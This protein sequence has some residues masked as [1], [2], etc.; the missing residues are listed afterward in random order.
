MDHPLTPEVQLRTGGG[1]DSNSLHLPHFLH[2]YTHVIKELLLQF[3]TPS[4]QGVLDCLLILLYNSPIL[5]FHPRHGTFIIILNR[6]LMECTHCLLFLLNHLHSLSDCVPLP[7]TL[8]LRSHSAAPPS[9]AVVASAGRC[10]S[11]A[12]QC[13]FPRHRSTWPKNSR[14]ASAAN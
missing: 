5:F 4:A 13:R 8:P 2:T 3:Q 9:L 11:P 14:R 12:W 10:P 1:S 7:S 6:F